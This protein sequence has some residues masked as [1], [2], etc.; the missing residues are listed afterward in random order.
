MADLSNNVREFD[1]CF[2][3]DL[4]PTLLQQ[5][6]VGSEVRGRVWHKDVVTLITSKP[7]LLDQWDSLPTSIDHYHIGTVVPG[8]VQR[9]K[10]FGVFLQVLAFSLVPII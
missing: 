1:E 4:A 9:I 8:V 2:Q 10:K 6:A 3:A 7:S 5:L